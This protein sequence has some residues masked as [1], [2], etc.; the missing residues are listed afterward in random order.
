IKNNS[1]VTANEI[2]DLIN[3]STRTVDRAIK[4]LRDKNI[5]IREGSLKSGYWKIIK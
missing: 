1:S 5:I 3:T 4:E 2:A